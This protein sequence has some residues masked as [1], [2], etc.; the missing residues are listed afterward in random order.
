MEHF[1]KHMAIFTKGR[2]YECQHN[3][4]GDIIIFPK[5]NNSIYVAIDEFLNVNYYIDHDEPVKTALVNM[6]ELDDLRYFV[7]LLI[8]KED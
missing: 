4:N 5:G 7:N 1:K 3:L 6:D 2:E 8:G